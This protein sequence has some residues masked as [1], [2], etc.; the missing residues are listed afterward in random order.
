[1]LTWTD[2]E[3]RAI[4]FQ[5][6]WRDCSGDEKQDGQTFEKDSMNVFGVDWHDDFHEHPI[7]SLDGITNTLTISCQNQGIFGLGLMANIYQMINIDT[8]YII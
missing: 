4:T 1:M 3:T 7:I 6:R 8:N 5:K 2:I